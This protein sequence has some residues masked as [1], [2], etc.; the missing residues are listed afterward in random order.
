MN[1]LIEV[2]DTVR[3]RKKIDIG[4]LADKAGVSRSYLGT[5]LS[6]DSDPKLSTLV[7][8]WQAMGLTIEDFAYEIV[9]MSGFAEGRVRDIVRQEIAKLNI[10][11]EPK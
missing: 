5:L 9:Q 10:S 4:D 2:L 7:A 6:G 1:K 3:R 8:I 11:I